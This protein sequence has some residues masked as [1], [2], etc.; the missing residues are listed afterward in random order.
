[1]AFEI[2]PTSDLDEEEE[3][4]SRNPSY[5]DRHSPRP[6]HPSSTHRASSLPH[7]AVYDARKPLEHG[8]CTS[9]TLTQSTTVSLEWDS[10]HQ[11]SP[12]PLAA[13]SALTTPLK[14]Y[15]PLVTPR[16]SHERDTFISQTPPTSP[17]LHPPTPW[18]VS[19]SRHASM[20]PE[21]L[22]IFAAH[23][24][25]PALFHET[26]L[27]LSPHHSLRASSEDIR[28]DELELAVSPKY[29]DV[30]S[31]VTDVPLPQHRSFEQKQ[32]SDPPHVANANQPASNRYGLRKREAR[33]LQPYAYD[34]RLYKHQLRHAPDAIVKAADLQTPSL[35]LSQSHR[36]EGD[37]E[38]YERDNQSTY[39]D[40]RASRHPS[41]PPPA[42]RR[43]TDD[44]SSRLDRGLNLSSRQDRFT[45]ANQ[46]QSSSIRQATAP[47][48]DVVVGMGNIKSFDYEFSGE[49]D[50]GSGPPDTVPIQQRTPSSQAGGKLGQRKPPRPAPFPIRLEKPAPL[51]AH[52]TLSR[53]DL[54]PDSENEQESGS[55]SENDQESGL[56][57][58]NDQESGSDLERSSSNSDTEEEGSPL[59]S[60]GSPQSSPPAQVQIAVRNTRPI[61][62]SK[63]SSSR[64][65]KKKPKPDKPRPAVTPRNSA[66]KAHSTEAVTRRSKK[67]RIPRD[68]PPVALF[69]RRADRIM[70]HMKPRA[71]QTIDLE[72]EELLS[73][74][75]PVDE[76][77]RRHTSHSRLEPIYRSRASLDKARSDRETAHTIPVD[78]GIQRLKAGI[79]FAPDSYLSRGW[80]HELL[81]I[82]LAQKPS[83]VPPD[84]EHNGQTLS[85]TSSPDDVRRFLDP[86]CQDLLAFVTLPADRADS[87]AIYW[88]TATHSVCQ[89]IYSLSSSART[90]EEFQPFLSPIMDAVN[91]MMA[92]LDSWWTEKTFST[93]DHAAACLR[94][95]WFCL[96]SVLR[97]RC[98]SHLQDYPES[99]F[100]I[101]NTLLAR[102]LEY[103]LEEV[104][105]SILAS[106]RPNPSLHHSA[107]AEIWIC[108]LH[109]FFSS[110]LKP[111]I[112]NL[113]G[114]FFWKT[115]E[116][117]M[118]EFTKHYTPPK[119]SEA[120]WDVIFGL[121]ALSQFNTHGLSTSRPRISSSWSFVLFALKRV[122]LHLTESSLA[123]HILKYRDQYVAI[124]V[125]RCALL[126]SRWMWRLDDGLPMLN[127]ILAVFKSR[128]FADL[129]KEPSGFSPFFT[130]GDPERLANETEDDTTF[131][132]FIKLIVQA[133]RDSTANRDNRTVKKLLSLIIPGPVDTLD[134]DLS[135][136]FNR[137]SVLSAAAYIDTS[138][139]YVRSL[140]SRARSFCDFSQA[141][142]NTR[143]V[144]I[145]ALG[146]LAI[147]VHQLGLP[148]DGALD[149][150][151]EMTNT[152]VIEHCRETSHEALLESTSAARSI[153]LLL[154]S[155]RAV[156]ERTLSDDRRAYP[157]PRFLC[158]GWVRRPLQTSTNLF[159]AAD[160]SDHLRRI[161]LAFFAARS[162]VIPENDSQ[163]KDPESQ[164]E[165]GHLEIDL[166]DPEV[167]LALG[168]S[169]GPQ[170]A[171]QKE[172][173]VSKVVIT[174][175]LPGLYRV[176]C[177]FA[178]DSDSLEEEEK[179]QSAVEWIDCW[180][181]CVT[182]A[183]E[184]IEVGK[185]NWQAFFA[186]A[187][188]SWSKIKDDLWSHR[189]SLLFMNAILQRRPC[190]FKIQADQFVG[191]WIVSLVAACVTVEC[192]YTVV[193][194]ASGSDH[195]LLEYVRTECDVAM[196]TH[197]QDAFS[198]HRLVFIKAIL[199]AI[200]QVAQADGRHHSEICLHFLGRMLRMMEINLETPI[201]ESS[202]STPPEYRFFCAQVYDALLDLPS[203]SSSR[204]LSPHMQRLGET[205]RPQRDADIVKY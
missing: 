27:Q 130:H 66:R 75:A 22:S 128:N 164:D 12:K 129:R 81:S 154:S 9:A 201:P 180:S 59:H 138:D 186:N 118:L 26:H 92:Q 51:P 149:W 121:C 133:A 2:V 60:S 190:V 23:S 44:G 106:S 37:I 91:S 83:Q 162:R 131:T 103:N 160:V 21:H 14:D 54:I 193:L 56:N 165:F 61:R 67:N 34:Q 158:G 84:C 119:A 35:D 5:W 173:E 203:L 43:R 198:N 202:S 32:A 112:I 195:P 105:A 88:S 107:L 80:L 159:K 189:L 161:I 20:G 101:L 57:S 46:R 93:T 169:A 147:Q 181:R 111:T 108:L 110:D 28:D 86:F 192:D 49:S 114:G 168:D 100:I 205:L 90:L 38:E 19:P 109:I 179:W 78:K 82:L 97:I 185:V 74:L 16:P 45:G 17:T 24:H 183:A 157:N 123:S 204:V 99:T 85:S 163:N 178:E 8:P 170:A 29:L 175:I 96:E 135:K 136:L 30:V 69:H 15:S 177:S 64:M 197:S 71:L 150:A 33:Q 172:G 102:L 77:H 58:E 98:A 79:Q 50:D 65:R 3:I 113:D 6:S 76:N 174:S 18:S 166:E 25:A 72:S 191:T 141:A 117:V 1:M 11:S 89:H 116:N 139:A 95:Y 171:F 200:V 40:A 194:F 63:Q 146:L 94:C 125:S 152:L 134:N 70:S 137:F 36:S 120:A 176:I 126:R 143:S 122:K 144:C 87:Q 153:C 151:E 188:Y 155:I 48:T 47:S 39:E 41:G 62:V 156:I 55:D 4:N 140:I 73:A 132:I 7:A 199:A 167:L 187:T 68:G 127:H 142:E 115:L 184:A 196:C 31:D 148:L 13:S 53:S 145:K 10:N 52:R 182:L 104:I 42:K 124:V